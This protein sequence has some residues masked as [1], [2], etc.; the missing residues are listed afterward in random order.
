MQMMF[1][2]LTQG[3]L[4]ETA[5]LDHLD[6]VAALIAACCHDYNH[7]G[8]NN[9]Y[10]VNA[11]TTRSVRYNDVSVQEGYHA[12]ESFQLLLEPKNNFLSDLRSED[13]KTFKR[14]MMGVILATDMA[15]H[16]E[17]LEIFKRKLQSNGIKRESKNGNL[18][19][20]RTNGKTLFE[21]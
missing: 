15:K 2:I 8:F 10:H 14:R 7:D 1:I 17:D 21:S 20:D 4:I 13:L 5:E 6:Q 11:I 9:A 12:A 16:T 3:K 19:L 18:F